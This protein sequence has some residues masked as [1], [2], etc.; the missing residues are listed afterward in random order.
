MNGLCHDSSSRA[1]FAQKP[2]IVRRCGGVEAV[3][4]ALLTLA[5]FTNAGGGSNEA[6]FVRYGLDGGHAQASC[7]CATQFYLAQSNDSGPAWRNHKADRR[8]CRPPVEAPPDSGAAAR[9]GC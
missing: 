7:I 5:C 1:S 8:L 4:A 6:A 3:E 2:A 9:T